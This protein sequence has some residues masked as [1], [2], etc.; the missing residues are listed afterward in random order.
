MH[1]AI[2]ATLYAAK[3]DLVISGHVHA[4]ERTCRSLNYTCT[5]DAPY[6]I[7]IGDGGNLEGLAEGWVSPQPAWSLFRQSS[8]GH[9]ELYAP[10]ATHLFWQWEQNPD[11]SNPA[12]DSFWIQKGVQGVHSAVPGTGITSTPE[13]RT[14]ELAAAARRPQQLP[15]SREGGQ[16]GGHGSAQQH[17]LPPSPGR[18][19]VENN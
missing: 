17:V 16:S 12:L 18:G 2:E 8:Y 9:G 15:P 14:P 3:V 10:N 19:G 13:F 1:A 11:F 6:Y 5:P 4:Y 7:T